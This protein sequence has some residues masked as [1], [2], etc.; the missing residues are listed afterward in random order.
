MPEMDDGSHRANGSQI[1][2]AGYR[3]CRNQWCE[4]LI[5]LEVAERT[6]GLCVPCWRTHLGA[7]VAHVEV[8]SRGER[9]KVSVNKRRRGPRTGKGDRDT[10]RKADKAKVRAMR[11][12]RAV[13][14]DLYDVF[15][16]EERAR[17][18]LD[19]WTVDSVINEPPEMRAEQTLAFAEVYA[20]LHE[21]GVDVDGLEVQSENEDARPR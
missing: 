6:R 15:Y 5:L 21:H 18:G 12:L 2:L 13:F 16:A 3:S 8:V 11:R 19:P 14:P 4:S 7:Q 9:L 17:V 10:H 20:R 1:D